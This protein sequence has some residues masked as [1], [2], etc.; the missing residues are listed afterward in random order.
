LK[1]KL[2]SG[3]KAR[4]PHSAGAPRRIVS[5]DFVPIARPRADRDATRTYLDQMGNV[6]LLTR[7][8]EVE[9]AKRIEVGRRALFD[10]VVESPVAAQALIRHAQRLESPELE[11]PANGP[12]EAASLSTV[13]ETKRAAGAIDQLQQRIEALLAEDAPRASKRAREARGAVSALRAEAV[14]IMRSLQPSNDL[15]D[16][17]V[18]AHKEHLRT[19]PEG[20]GGNAAR[21]ISDRIRQAEGRVQRAK[22]ELIGANLRLVV[23]IAK[24]Y[25]HRGL[26]LLD[27]IQEGN[28]GLMKAV[29]KFEYRRG[30]KFS[31]Y[32]TWWIRQA[33]S[34]AVADQSRTI[35]IPVHMVESANQV[36]RVSR[37][38]VQALGREPTTDEIAAALGSTEEHVRKVQRLVKEP[39]SMETPV[40]DDGASVLS[41]FIPDDRATDPM[42][43]AVAA[44]LADRTSDLLQTLTAR[45]EKVLRMRFG[46]N[47]KSEHTLE[48]VGRSFGV[49]R[50]RIR[51]IE[52]NA[53]RKLGRVRRTR[54][55]KDFL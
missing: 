9:I 17:M 11:P 30:Y 26:D 45:E 10:A 8:Q 3:A 49:T 2:S 37:S 32:G 38:L 40:G 41:D 47:E 20:Q 52:A 33:I 54:S 53:L 15:L 50:E 34:R 21:A 55:V 36:T 6:P 19:A 4:A 23:S 18:A 14:V 51:Q 31:T 43:H 39:L 44:D 13:A 12:D 27:L 29:E 1:N 22:G 5:R 28:L 48:E 46:V 42:A 25:M 24:R 16:G 35:R 7:E